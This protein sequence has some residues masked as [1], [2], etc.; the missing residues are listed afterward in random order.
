M[1]APLGASPKKS[2]GCQRH[3][4]WAPTPAPPKSSGYQPQVQWV[5]APCPV[6]ASP[7]SGGRQSQSPVGARP[8]GRQPQVQWAPAPAPPKSS[9]RPVAAGA[10]AGQNQV[11]AS[12]SVRLSPVGAS[13]AAP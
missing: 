2:S 7:K 10:N 8:I 1:P 3:V 11:S 5:P 4:Q 6:G 9:C 13:P 12:A